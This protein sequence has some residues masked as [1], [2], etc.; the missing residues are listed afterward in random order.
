MSGHSAGQ[1][2]YIVGASDPN[3]ELQKE[4]FSIIMLLTLVAAINNG[5]HPTL[6]N[7]SESYQE[8]FESYQEPFDRSL[9]YNNRVLN[10]AA[11]LLVRNFDVVAVTADHPSSDQ[12]YFKL[13]VIHPD[14]RYRG[15]RTFR[16]GVAPYPDHQNKFVGDKDSEDGVLVNTGNSHLRSIQSGIWDDLFAIP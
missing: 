5:G 4:F 16:S 11:T 12:E 1:N 8:A 7:R 13:L 9:P 3:A 6:V 10:A 14:L 2:L 15:E